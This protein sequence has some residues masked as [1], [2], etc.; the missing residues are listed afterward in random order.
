MFPSARRPAPAPPDKAAGV[1]S[2]C[3]SAV[4]EQDVLSGRAE[5][6]DDGRLH[7]GEC[8]NRLVAGLIC[9]VCYGRITRS[10]MKGG[11]LKVVAKRVRHGHCGTSA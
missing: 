4:R 2:S 3:L 8:F 1:C 5:R 7:C 10:D 6:L 9:S 11:K